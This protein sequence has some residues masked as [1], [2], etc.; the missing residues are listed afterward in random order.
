MNNKMLYLVIFL[1]AISPLMRSQTII[2]VNKKEFRNDKTGFREA[3]KHI[4]TGDD[5]YSAKG[6]WYGSAYDEYLK[7][8]AYNGANPELNYKTGVSA[9][10]SDNKEDAAGFLLKA[11][12]E[13]S[14]LTEDVLLLTGRAL[15]YAGRFTEAIEKLNA[16]LNSPVKKPKQNVINA[17]KYLE[18]CGAA[19][20]VTKDTLRVGFRNMGSNINSNADEYSEVFS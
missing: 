18:E 2:K 6:I 1:L 17:K 4:S 14:D 10:F 11:I 15:Q 7:A 9:L 13:G 16:Y 3:W 5:F 8:V 19:L 20:E 12:Q